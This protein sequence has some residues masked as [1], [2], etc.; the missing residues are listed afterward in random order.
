MKKKTNT[1]L[2]VSW[3]MDE[4]YK[5]FAEEGIPSTDE[6]VQK[7]L[8]PST[9]D[10]I[11]ESA[12]R[13]GW[14]IFREQLSHLEAKGEE[15]EAGFREFCAEKRAYSWRGEGIWYS[16]S[17]H[18][19]IEGQGSIEWKVSDT[20]LLRAHLAKS[21]S[22]NPYISAD[23]IFEIISNELDDVLNTEY[24]EYIEEDDYYPPVGE[25]FEF[26]YIV[27]GFCRKCGLEVTSC[28]FDGS[29]SG[30]EPN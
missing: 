15:R 17:V 27:N 24:K 22:Q 4:L 1:I 30:Y 25:D 10:R 3:K 2:T 13:K 6:N 23:D 16:G 7:V 14:D 5:A 20:E 19:E 28:D 26:D 29:T 9:L 11:R 18:V 12:L 8:S 21:L